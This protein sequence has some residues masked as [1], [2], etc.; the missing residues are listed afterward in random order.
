MDIS[1]RRVPSGWDEGIKEIRTRQKAATPVAR[2][3][4]RNSGVNPVGGSIA[5]AKQEYGA[6]WW[7][8]GYT[9]AQFLAAKVEDG[10]M[11]KE[12]A[13][14]WVNQGPAEPKDRKRG[15]DYVK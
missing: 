6:L 9:W 1:N 10:R 7:P 13:V 2:Q 4:R 5:R 8:S 11:S 14:A 15:G 3:P 12:Q